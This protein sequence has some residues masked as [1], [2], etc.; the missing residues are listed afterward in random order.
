MPSPMSVTPV[1]A[2]PKRSHSLP[3]ITQGITQVLTPSTSAQTKPAA[4]GQVIGSQGGGTPTNSQNPSVVQ[5]QSARLPP[6]WTQ[7]ATTTHVGAQ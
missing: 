2:N 1:H 6:G 3:L 7:S 4:A 5:V